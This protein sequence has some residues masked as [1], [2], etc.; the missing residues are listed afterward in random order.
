[1]SFKIFHL[2]FI[3]GLISPMALTG[4]ASNP[5]TK[6]FAS[7]ADPSQEIAN[8]KTGI[9]N[10]YS[11]QANMLSPNY[12]KKAEKQLKAAVEARADNESNKD[13]LKEV[14]LGNAWLDKANAAVAF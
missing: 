1:M 5:P 14:A 6:E 10:T 4:C 9:D 11:D 12:I 7:T 2:V 8:L 13:V 3:A